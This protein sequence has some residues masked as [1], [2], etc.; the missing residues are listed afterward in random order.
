MT[1]RWWDQGRELLKWVSPG[2]ASMSCPGQGPEL[3]W[4]HSG[5]GEWA[6]LSRPPGPGRQDGDLEF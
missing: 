2:P 3:C 1:A 6:V 4:R 5:P